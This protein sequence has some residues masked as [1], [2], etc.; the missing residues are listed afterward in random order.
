[1]AWRRPADSVNNTRRLGCFDVSPVGLGCMNLSH[2][3]GRPPSE[4]EASSLLLL[5]LDLG[6]THFDTAALYGFGANEQLLGRVLAPHRSRF[7]LASKGGLYGLKTDKGFKRVIDTSPLGLRANCETSLRNLQ[8][9]VIDLYYLHRWD[10]Q[11]PIE[12]SIGALA[13]LVREG[14]IRHIGLSEVSADTLARAHRVHPI[15]AV[16]SEYSVLTRNPEIGVL[17]GCKA[18]G[19]AFVAFSP[20]GRGMLAADPV[21]VAAFADNDIRRGMP[22]FKAENYAANRA[23]LRPFI[24]FAVSQGWTP[25]QLALAWLLSRDPHVLVIPGT[26]RES[27]LRDNTQAASLG[28]DPAARQ[29][30]EDIVDAIRL[31]GNRYSD[32]TQAEVDTERMPSEAA[33][34]S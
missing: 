21:D 28:L 27:H 10:R 22:R 13:M 15:A 34:S 14:K 24:E 18:I 9:D 31:R 30:L 17:Q 16:Q 33:T 32:A 1:M 29:G 8:T 7:T 11:V 5:A 6:V 26:T 12:D 20:V 25:S 3:Y 2:A 23:A 4:Q 19:A